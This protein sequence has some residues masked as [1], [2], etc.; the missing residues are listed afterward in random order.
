MRLASPLSA[1]AAVLWSYEAWVKI[2]VLY[3]NIA[4]HAAVAWAVTTITVGYITP[5]RK[6]VVHTAIAGLVVFIMA[7]WLYYPYTFDPLATMVPNEQG[8]LLVNP[9]LLSTSNTLLN[10]FSLLMLLAF[11]VHKYRTDRPIGAY[12]DTLLF[13]FGLALA[14]DTAEAFLQVFE[15]SFLVISQWAIQVVYAACAVSLA[16]R[17]KF[18][19]QTIADYYESQCVSDDPT[20]DRRIGGL[21]A[22]FYGLFLIR[23]RL[24]RKYSLGQARPE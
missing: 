13:L 18:K 23:K 8:D 1:I 19:S 6:R 21:T 10:I 14:I 2:Y 3:S 17:L 5:P 7:A 12:A 15:L 20:I 16:L 11:Y 24:G 22:L 9:A 4:V